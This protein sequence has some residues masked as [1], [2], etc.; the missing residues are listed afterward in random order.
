MGAMIWLRVH[1]DHGLFFLSWLIITVSSADTGA[2]L[3]GSLLRGPKLVPRIS[4]GKT[5]SGLIG[6][7]FCG[8]IIG[9]GILFV[10]GNFVDLELLPLIVVLVTS[11]LILISQLG[12][13]LESFIKRAACV[14]DSS[15][16]IPGHGG[17]LDRM[18]GVMAAALFMVG[19]VM[20]N[21]GRLPIWQQY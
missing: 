18:D 14:K 16:L 10:Y 17:L 2:Y 6:G 19:F 11:S 13:L 9:C 15:K 3:L 1:F 5:W 7:L 12:D 8:L 4:P 20:A 21:G